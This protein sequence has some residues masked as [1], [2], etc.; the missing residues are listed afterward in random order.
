MGPTTEPRAHSADTGDSAQVSSL[1]PYPGLRSFAPEEHEFFFGREGHVESL[2]QKLIAKRFLLVTGASGCGKSSLVKTGLLNFL[3]QQASIGDGDWAYIEF[4]PG[5]APVWEL[6]GG[7]RRALEREQGRNP[8]ISAGAQMDLRM[9]LLANEAQALWRALGNGC[10][11]RP[12]LYRPG[13]R[14]VLLV[15][16]FEEV[17]RYESRAMADEAR[18]MVN[19][20]LAGPLASTATEDPIGEEVRRALHVVMTMRTEYLDRCIEFEGLLAAINDGFAIATNL[21]RAELHKAIVGPAKRAGGAVSLKLAEAL[22]DDAE[23]LDRD[24]LPLLQHALMRCWSFAS[25]ENEEGTSERIRM[26]SRHYGRARS[27]DGTAVSEHA[28]EAYAA[29][30]RS[31]ERRKRLTEILFRELTDRPV[32]GPEANQDRRR[33]RRIQSIA[34]VAKL[35]D[36]QW[37]QLIP[38]IEGFSTLDTNFLVIRDD[39][40]GATKLASQTTID[41]A[42][43]LDISH[44]A[45]IRNWDKLKEW[46]NDEARDAM[47][48]RDA[49]TLAARYFGNRQKGELEPPQTPSE[50]RE[51]IDWWNK[52]VDH[53]NASEWAKRYIEP[54]RLDSIRTYFREAQAYYNGKKRRKLIGRIGL[55]SFCLALLPLVALVI[56]IREEFDERTSKHVEQAYTMGSY[57]LRDPALWEAEEDQRPYKDILSLPDAGKLSVAHDWGYSAVG[58]LADDPVGQIYNTVKGVVIGETVL[59]RRDEIFADVG[60]ILDYRL[61][62]EKTLRQVSVNRQNEEFGRQNETLSLETSLEMHI[63]RLDQKPVQVSWAQDVHHLVIATDPGGVCVWKP[64]AGTDGQLTEVPC[65]TAL[66]NGTRIAKFAPL[67]NDWIAL[68]DGGAFRVSA[69][70][71]NSVALDTVNSNSQVAVVGDA[72]YV[73]SDSSASNLPTGYSDRNETSFKLERVVSGI[74]QKDRIGLSVAGGRPTVYG[75]ENGVLVREGPASR[76]TLAFKPMKNEKIEDGDFSGDGVSGHY[77][78]QLNGEAKPRFSARSGKVNMSRLVLVEGRTNIVISEWTAEW[79]H[80]TKNTLMQPPLTSEA[81][82]QDQEKIHQ[83]ASRDFTIL[84]YDYQCSTNIQSNKKEKCFIAVALDAEYLTGSKSYAILAFRVQ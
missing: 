32:E 5:I 36:D 54:T 53:R 10:L 21:N 69:K 79:L 16:Q 77:V 46:V 38:I 56:A 45:L 8:P 35:G 47:L 23:D 4:K 33:P 27:M 59:S 68:F 26:E 34:Q 19:T 28:N 39:P 30:C 74:A 6:A 13:Q 15:D 55:G 7:L 80:G 65:S 60:H 82:S 2:Y 42:S 66:G 73:V 11:G 61:N 43:L 49:D 62:T 50:L 63:L 22:K 57:V 58:Q 20:V 41:A 14:I 83:I 72:V 44:E 18:R 48:L 52:V 84:D 64:S 24:R 81:A 17:F 25:K 3:V 51:R 71:C 9:E 37:Q 29:I 31:D 40:D 70:G 12:P 75:L 78:L 67:A 1:R 76:K